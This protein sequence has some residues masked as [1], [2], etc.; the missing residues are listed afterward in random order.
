[1]EFGLGRTY[2][3][4][5]R[6]LTTELQ[7]VAGG[8]LPRSLTPPPPYYSSP[9][10]AHPFSNPNA[11]QQQSLN[12]SSASLPPPPAPSGPRLQPVSGNDNRGIDRTTSVYRRTTESL[13]HE[14]SKSGPDLH[15][16]RSYSSNERGRHPNDKDGSPG[17][18]L[19]GSHHPDEGRAIA[20]PSKEER[21]ARTP[22]GA[23]FDFDDLFEGYLSQPSSYEKL[24]LRAKPIA[25]A[26]DAWAE[27]EEERLRQ[28][29]MEMMFPLEPSAKALGKRRV[30]LF[31]GEED[32]AFGG[33]IR[34]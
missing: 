28:M 12:D 11:W 1:M 25:Y 13:I 30:V 10:A 34:R 4:P 14:S 7:A 15:W 2:Y 21:R 9:I 19:G 33:R 17:A 26:Y 27:R 31:S 6:S 24:V 32:E 18:P 16:T 5:E 29:K 22:P 3:S 20:G 23:T 8:S